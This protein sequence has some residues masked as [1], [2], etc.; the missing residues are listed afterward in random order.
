MK[1]L[2]L[3]TL[4]FL[5]SASVMAQQSTLDIAGIH[6]LVDQST[7]ENKL[8]VKARNQQAINDANEQ[9][10]LTLLA[11]LKNTYRT[12]QQRY[13][14]LGTAINIADIGI[15]ATPM[16]EHIIDYQRQIIQLAEKNPAIIALGY[17]TEI[18]F[19]EKAKNLVSYIIGLSL[20]IGDVNQMKASDRKMLFDYII[21][22]LSTIQELSA[23]MVNTLQYSS[24]SAL[25]RSINP[26]Q[27]FIDQDKGIAEQIIQ[28]AK[29]LK[30]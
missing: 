25:L 23:N 15:Q 21:S 2:I 9:S 22:E 16:V 1:A 4:S 19:V 24:L 14:A 28:N 6:Q 7:A 27:N 11:K 30:Q 3:F 12:L 17:Q 29:Y 13:N 26:F 10:N 8:Q 20:C 18:E 5:L